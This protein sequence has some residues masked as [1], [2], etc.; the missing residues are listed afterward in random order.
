MNQCH[1]VCLFLLLFLIPFE[2]SFSLS[3]EIL[4]CTHDEQEEDV[5]EGNYE[6]GL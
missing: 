2:D 5:E 4:S 6:G 1:P 3:K